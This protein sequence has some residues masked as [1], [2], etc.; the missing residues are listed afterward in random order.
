M[1]REIPVEEIKSC[2]DYLNSRKERIELMANELH[3][4]WKPQLRTLGIDPKELV[5]EVDTLRRTGKN[6][7]EACLIVGMNRDKY[8]YWKKRI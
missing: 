4:D 1:I 7:L 2:L 6:A 8:N 3:K 5:L